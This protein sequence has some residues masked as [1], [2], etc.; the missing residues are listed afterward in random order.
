[1]FPN[2]C[3]NDRFNVLD[4][5]GL[6]MGETGVHK[7]DGWGNDTRYQ[8]EVEFQKNNALTR[9]TE[10]GKRGFLLRTFFETLQLAGEGCR[11]LP[12][13]TVATRSMKFYSKKLGVIRVRVACI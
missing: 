11:L 3:Q 2:P 7:P 10:K 4:L 6:E 9:P 1:V 5:C 8:S 13:P 12:S